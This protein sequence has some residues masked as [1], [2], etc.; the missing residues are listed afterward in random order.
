MVWLPSSRAAP[1]RRRRR[2]QQQQQEEEEEEAQ[3]EAQPA[4]Q[5]PSGGVT[6]LA[7]ATARRFDPF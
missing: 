4:E 3:A 6:G 5:Q 1:L 2:Q 7:D